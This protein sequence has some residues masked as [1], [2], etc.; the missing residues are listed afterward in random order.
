MNHWLYQ[1]PFPAAPRNHLSKAI[2]I[3]LYAPRHLWGLL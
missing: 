3:C 1:T 2:G